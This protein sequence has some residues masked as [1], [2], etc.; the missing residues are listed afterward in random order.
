MV[1]DI[2]CAATGCCWAPV[3]HTVATTRSVATAAIENNIRGDQREEEEDAGWWLSSPKGVVSVLISGTSLYG[4]ELT[5][6]AIWFL[7]CAD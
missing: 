2:F 7:A 6:V 3:F 4:K 1:M 5:M